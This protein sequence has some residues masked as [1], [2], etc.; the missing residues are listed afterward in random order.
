MSEK[1]EQ[2]AG[3]DEGIVG[4]A[5]GDGGHGGIKQLVTGLFLLWTVFVAFLAIG[6]DDVRIDQ[7][8]GAIAGGGSR[9]VGAGH[10][11]GQGIEGILAVGAGAGGVATFAP[12]GGRDAEGEG[13]GVGGDRIAEELGQESDRIRKAHVAASLFVFLFVAALAFLA[14]FG[15]LC[16]AGLVAWI[17]V[18]WLLDRWIFTPRELRQVGH[19]CDLSATWLA[20]WNHNVS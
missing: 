18:S 16:A 10:D 20:R 2:T 7:I 11:A 5:V 3:G 12:D 13:H 8:G 9:G 1:L 14:A 6:V 17:P 4:A 19:W 15:S